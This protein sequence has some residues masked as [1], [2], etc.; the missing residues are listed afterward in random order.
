M[1]A[2]PTFFFHFLGIFFGNWSDNVNFRIPRITVI[3]P[4]SSTVEKNAIGAV[5]VNYTVMV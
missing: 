2:S 1:N 3:S 4:V 5:V